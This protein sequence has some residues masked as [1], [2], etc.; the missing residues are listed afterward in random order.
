MTSLQTL[1]I[2]SVN[3]FLVILFIQA[4][5]SWFPSSKALA[6]HQLCG[7]ITNP[8]VAPIRRV[9]PPLRIGGGSIDLSFLV[10]YLAARMLV[11]PLLAGM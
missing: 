11:L 8:I 4:I 7:R 5:A 6:I 3:L 1:A 10:I 2:Y 9:L